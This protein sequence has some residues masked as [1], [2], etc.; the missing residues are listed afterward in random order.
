MEEFVIEEKWVPGGENDVNKEIRPNYSFIHSFLLRSFFFEVPYCVVVRQIYNYDKLL[1]GVHAPTLCKHCTVLSVTCY[2]ASDLFTVLKVCS[3]A[4]FNAQ[5]VTKKVLK[6][7]K[8]KLKNFFNI[9]AGFVKKCPCLRPPIDDD[10]RELDYRHCS[11]A[12]VP[13]EVFNF[14]RTLEEL[15]ELFYCHG[16]RKLSISDNEITSIP[17]A[18]ASLI[19]LEEFD[20]SVIDMPENI[21]CCKYL[22]VVDASV[23]PLGKLS[24]LKILEIRENHLKT[25]PKSFSRLTELER[26]DIG[27]NEFGELP[28]VIGNLS[29]LLELW[30]DHNQ[31][32]KIT[33]TIGNLKQ[34]MFLDASKNNLQSLPS[35]IEDCSSLADL[36]LT[37]NHIQALPESLGNLSNLTT[38]KVD[39]NQLTCLPTSIGGLSSLSELN[40]SVNELEDLPASLGLLRNLRTFYVDDNYLT[41]IPAELGSCNGITV[42]SLRNNK[43]EYIPD[44]LGRIPRLRVLNLS[45][46][47]L[48]FLPFTITK[49]KEL[50]ALW[51]SENQTR[52]LVPLQ[53]D[54]DPDTGRKILTCYLLP[55]TE[56]DG[57]GD[58]DNYGDGDS[59][60]ASMWD[61]ERTR[62]QQI[63]FDFDEGL[64][65]EGTLVRR[66]TPYPKEMREKMRHAQNLAM[67]Q[68]IQGNGDVR[69][70]SGKENGGFEGEEKF[71]RDK[72][73]MQQHRHSGS[74]LEDNIDSSSHVS[75]SS[76]K[77]EK[78]GRSSRET[79]PVNSE[80]RSESPKKEIDDGG[81][82][83]VGNRSVSHG[84][85]TTPQPQSVGVSA[86]SEKKDGPHRN[87]GGFAYCSPKELAKSFSQ[88]GVSEQNVNANFQ[89]PNVYSAPHNHRHRKMRNYDS[90]TGYR[91]ESEI[92]FYR[93]QHLNNINVKPHSRGGYGRGYDSESERFIPS[94]REK[95]RDIGYSS[96]VEGYTGRIHQDIGYRPVVPLQ[97]QYNA[98][99]SLPYDIHQTPE[100]RRIRIKNDELYEQQMKNRDLNKSADRSFAP[101]SP[102]MFHRSKIIDQSTPVSPSP[103][104][105]VGFSAGAI[106][107]SKTDGSV[108]N[109]SE[110]LDRNSS[111]YL[112]QNMQINSGDITQRNEHVR[113]INILLLATV[114]KVEIFVCIK[115]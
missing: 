112:E 57:S 106:D 47:R 38:L 33:P 3:E 113:I 80:K 50:Q 71:A 5:T 53:S 9:M 110:N 15:Y 13:S 54:H 23:N 30:C 17:P 48:K 97:N 59:F 79:S 83:E 58:L 69:W 104:N 100:N 66:P 115:C 67:R 99:S 94:K 19:N 109:S 20:L 14:E 78:S 36:H 28:D 75:K 56:P 37:T 55:Q 35:E 61:E 12:D 105:G 11:L 101:P 87:S 91:S 46:N 51:L 72:A 85:S 39:D 49:L 63:K 2:K 22:R 60:H 44:E 86:N 81:F 93:Q 43:L 108:I 89:K 7:Y 107:K 45:N 1:L 42:L 31:I 74:G 73:R 24:K 64:D 41:F 62:R 68:M 25:L 21:K 84:T 29:S 82:S 90:D 8:L 88:Y 96:D 34:L 4:M 52:P 40:V 18:I 114:C 32:T 92:Q 95:R 111:N 103:P 16:I 27:H 10:V 26:L 6:E 76:H 70:N 98:S 102:G 77:K 65:D